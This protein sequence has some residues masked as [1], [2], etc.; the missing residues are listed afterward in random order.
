MW[1]RSGLV[2][3]RPS[4]W[5]LRVSQSCACQEGSVVGA[6]Q[7]NPEVDPSSREAMNLTENAAFSTSMNP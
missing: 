4:A 7:R 1:I 6:S 3:A 5:E 2:R